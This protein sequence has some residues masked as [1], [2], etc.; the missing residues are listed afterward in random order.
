MIGFV[1]EPERLYLILDVQSLLLGF[2]WNLF[3]NLRTLFDNFALVEIP[4]SIFKL[5]PLNLFT[6]LS[7]K[8]LQV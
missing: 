6:F 4:L 1:N 2:G 3:K 8:L 7:I 5:E